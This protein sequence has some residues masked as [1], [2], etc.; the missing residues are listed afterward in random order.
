[1]GKVLAELRSAAFGQW[2]QVKRSTLKLETD[3][4]SAEIWAWIDL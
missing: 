3:L 1:M 4:H 2:N